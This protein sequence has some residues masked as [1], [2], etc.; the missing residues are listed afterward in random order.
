[1]RKTL[2]RA[3]NLLIV[4]TLLLALVP[5]TAAEPPQNPRAGHGA[6]GPTGTAKAT[7]Q[8]RIIVLLAEFPDLAH[9]KQPA[10]PPSDNSRFWNYPN[11]G[12]YYRDLF[13][14]SSTSLRQYFL[15][16]SYNQF[17]IVSVPW[18]S[19]NNGSVV[20]SWGHIT[21]TQNAAV[22]GNDGATVGDD[23]G[24]D[25]GTTYTVDSFARE[26]ITQGTAYLNSIGFTA[27]TWGNFDGNGDGYI[28]YLFI[29][30]AGQGQEDGGGVL[31]NGAA[32]GANALTSRIH[33]F[34]GGLP[35]MGGGKSVQRCAIVPED[36]T[37]GEL[38]WYM[39]KMMGAPETRNTNSRYP[40]DAS[41]NNESSAAFWDLM[42]DGYLLGN[43]I[44]TSPANMNAYQRI[45]QGWV[46]P[47]TYSVSDQ[48]RNVTLGR[49]EGNNPYPKA[50]RINLPD[51][52]PNQP[53]SG[54]YYWWSRMDTGE[55]HQLQRTLSVTTLPATLEYWAWH[56]TES[57]YDTCEVQVSYSGGPYS[58]VESYSGQSNGWVQH[59]IALGATG[60]VDV[61][62]VYTTDGDKTGVGWFL[63]D[64]TLTQGGSVTW[65]DDVEAG[66]TGWV[67]TSSG[68]NQWTRTTPPTFHHYY[69]AEWRSHYGFDSGYNQSV[70]YLTNPAAGTSVWYSY[71]PGLLVWYVNERW[72]PGENYA[73]FR[74]GEG[75]LLPIDAHPTPVLNGATPF[76][77]RVQMNDAP[78]NVDATISQALVGIPLGSLSAVPTFYDGDTYWNPTDP[79]NSVKHPHFGVRLNVEEHAADMSWGKIGFS[80]DAGNFDTST[81][82]VDK[83]T[84][85]PGDTLLYTVVIRN[86]GVA[87]AY[88]ANMTD[89]LPSEVTY[90]GYVD[91]SAGS[92]TYDAG[93]NAIRWT[94]VATISTPVTVTF[95][96]R[97]NVPLPNGST[98][99]NTANIYEG[100]TLKASKSCTTT[101]VSAPDLATSSKGVDPA[102]VRAGDPLTYTLVLQNTGTDNATVTVT[103]PIPP[104]STYVAG[105]ATASSGT[106]GYESGT[107]TWNGA[108]NVGTPVTLTFR[109]QVTPGIAAGT[110][111]CNV[112]TI[113]DQIHA[114]FTRQACA[115]V[116]SAANF[117]TSSKSVDKATAYPGNTLTY[118]IT[119]N[120]SGNATGTINLTDTIPAYT[121]Y[122]PGSVTNATYDADLNQIRWSGTLA[123]LAYRN[124]TFRV[125]VTIPLT[126][127]TV[128]TNTA[129]IND[130][131]YPVIERTATTTII[132]EPDLTTSRKTVQATSAASGGVLTYTLTLTNTG[133]SNAWVCITD[134][135]PA[136]TSIT[137]TVA[138]TASVGVPTYDP[139]YNQITWCGP[140]A[141]GESVWIRFG[142]QIDLPPDSTGIITNTAI[143]N[144]GVHPPFE[145][146]VTTRVAMLWLSCPVGAPYSG[147][148]LNVDLNVSNVGD[149]QG[150]EAHITF[151]ITNVEVVSIN[152][153]SW[154]APSLWPVKT[155][156]NLS[157]TIDIATVLNAQ[158]VGKSGS[159][160]LCTIVFRAKAG[161]SVPF[162]ITHSELSTAPLPRID[163]IPHNRSSCDGT[164]TGRIVQGTAIMQGRTD[165]SG[166]QVLVGDVPITTTVASGHYQFFTPSSSFTVKLTNDGYL[167]AQ[168]NVTVG[169]TTLITL[170]DVILLGGDVVGGNVIVSRGPGCPGSPTVTIPGPPEGVVNIQDLT[171]V[172]GKFGMTST[173]AW[174]GPDPCYP[175]YG[176]Y[177]VR[178][179]HLAYR[180]DIN[181]DGRVNIFDLV[182]V[183]T[184]FN[185][186]APSPWP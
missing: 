20:G 3:L 144:D 148:F 65:A 136:G 71:N 64:F 180:A 112:A 86:T 60:D 17:D 9:D 74:P 59:T 29:V 153:G 184:N 53:H 11:T 30:H 104:G 119:I 145:R 87:D 111:I 100:T 12:D 26:V 141:V 72:A 2:S 47:V 131:V 98:I 38:A 158:P 172:G 179:F 67:V 173:D 10:P 160:T 13:F 113:N 122:V 99:V 45:Q 36:V 39:A 85:V 7:V 117:N 27:S 56:D 150:V 32:L 51:Y 130:H 129:E 140:V 174:W 127:G 107:I 55:W 159:G 139:V 78:F 147:E 84:V 41:G 77:P 50:L 152:E 134:T 108:V 96:V 88:T 118:T 89:T 135:I 4:A 68:L 185:K 114:P 110:Q 115:T 14:R 169:A 151:P 176:A 80:I 138:L 63:D 177:D 161:G 105:S 181:N 170:P 183:G 66:A 81:K 24:T 54:S 149:L 137:D 116:I 16:Q 21:V 142:V 73:G 46:S 143:I 6:Q 123:A 91:A 52:S 62:F 101:V 120:N 165:H 162:Q 102:T 157:G 28:D 82:G 40:T 75:F 79:D 31:S 18:S 126:N 49:I 164:V 156:D 121:T 34:S 42:A 155:W 103:D 132:S 163:P 154:F 33:T 8:R 93:A 90:D 106:I 175:E 69:L 37:V 70:S 19:P 94:G 97:T 1:M 128:I 133:T 76:R 15:E 168:R 178:N 167:W 171:F 109:A 5:V 95:R 48:P 25:P 186:V 61:R 43:K 44:G 83:A 58:T 92:V 125:S 22:Y 57:G 124:I 146:S 166:V 23:L 182:A 35:A